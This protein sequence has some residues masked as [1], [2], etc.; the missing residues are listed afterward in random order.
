[1]KVLCLTTLTAGATAGKFFHG[2]G[3]NPAR[4]PQIFVRDTLPQLKELP[5][6][7]DWRDE[8]DTHINFASTSRN[9]H[10]PNCEYFIIICVR[11]HCTNN[12]QSFP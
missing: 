11:G 12:V 8:S 6:S 10:I 7:W 9:Q 3:I 4:A 5:K 1:M 2:V